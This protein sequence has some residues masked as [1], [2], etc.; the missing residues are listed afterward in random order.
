MCAYEFIQRAI[1]I[2]HTKSITHMYALALCT[3]SEHTQSKEV[4]KPIPFRNV[5]GNNDT[6]DHDDD[7]WT[8]GNDWTKYMTM[9]KIE[10][11]A[12]RSTLLET[13]N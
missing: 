8:K 13:T 10:N 6:D 1:L 9:G 11:F 4:N 3:Q 12:I 7:D 2:A 5:V